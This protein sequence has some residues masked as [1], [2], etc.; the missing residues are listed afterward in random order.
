VGALS[1]AMVASMASLMRGSASVLHPGVG[2]A[3]RGVEVISGAC[4]QGA[5]FGYHRGVHDG[6]SRGTRP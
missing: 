2:L 1:G 6:D 5:Y 4:A 3:E